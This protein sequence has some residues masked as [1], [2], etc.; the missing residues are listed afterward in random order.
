MIMIATGTMFMNM[1]G[2]RM[3]RVSGIQMV[4]RIAGVLTAMRCWRG[5]L[6]RRRLMNVGLSRLWFDRF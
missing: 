6:R 3:K 4:M 1:I 5:W 2:V